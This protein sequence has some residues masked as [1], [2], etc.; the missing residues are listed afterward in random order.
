MTFSKEVS[1]SLSPISPAEV[2]VFELSETSTLFIEVISSRIIKAK[3]FFKEMTTLSAIDTA[4]S[5]I[6]LIQPM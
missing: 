5:T 1:N 4:I 2:D 3:G 6:S